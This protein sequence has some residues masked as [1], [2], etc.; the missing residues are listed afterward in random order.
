MS[1]TKRSDRTL[2][3]FLFCPNELCI[4]TFESEEEFDLHVL[5]DQH[6]TN[7]SSLRTNDKVKIM[8]FEKTKNINTSP[9]VSQPAAIKNSSTN[10]PRH[11][12]SFAVE[13]WALRKRK[14]F[15]PIDKNVKEF[16]KS[17]FDEEKAYGKSCG[18]TF[19]QNN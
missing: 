5:A 19:F 3:T 10:I 14:K 16:I 15:K 18:S 8:L 13:G 1:S 12:K 2:K 6:T 17:I 4:N 9:I 7:E 11:Y